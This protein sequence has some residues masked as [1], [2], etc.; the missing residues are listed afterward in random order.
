M[1]CVM[2]V[3]GILYNTKIFPQGWRFRRLKDLPGSKNV[4]MALAWAIVTTVLPRMQFSL[5]IAPATVVAF[6]FAFTI[7]F[8][9][10][11]MSDMLDIQSDRLLG[12]ETIPVLIGEVGT[13]ALLVALSSGVFMLLVL[14]NPL[15]LTGPL[16]FFLSTSV[17][18]I[19]ICFRICGRRSQFS[20]VVREGLLE[21]IYIVAGVI[22]LL[23]WAANIRVA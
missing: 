8:I 4:S 17:I 7:V 23:W 21:T 12:R 14:A 13:N 16:S 2:S 22:A 3:L 15:S 19:W 18:Y 11:A 10:S 6:L 20:G 9:R 1:L 5:S